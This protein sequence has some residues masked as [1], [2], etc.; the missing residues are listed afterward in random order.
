LAASY[1]EGTKAVEN[2]HGAKAPNA[3]N[4]SVHKDEADAAAPQKKATG[5]A[6]EISNQAPP[7]HTKSSPNASQQIQGAALANDAVVKGSGSSNTRNVHTSCKGLTIQ[8]EASKDYG[9]DAKFLWNFGDGFFSNEANPAHTFNKAGTFDVS[10][11]VTSSSTGQISSNVVQASIQ[12]LEAPKAKAEWELISPKELQVL[13][14]SLG[15]DRAEFRLDGA[16]QQ[17][18]HALRI[19]LESSKVKEMELVVINESGCIDTL[20]QSLNI[21]AFEADITFQ[22]LK[23]KQTKGIAEGEIFIFDLNGSTLLYSGSDLNAW[24]PQQNV[25][26]RVVQLDKKNGLTAVKVGTLKN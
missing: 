26:Y 23:E 22:T 12:V 1:Q 2:L 5:T 3:S 7:L 13:N 24:S 19:P 14:L 10:L 17:S 16:L 9:K 6:K 15:E 20:R 11:S 18:T 25:A 21:E 4:T 8:F